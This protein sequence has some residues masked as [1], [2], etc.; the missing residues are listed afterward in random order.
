MPA[1][2][3]AKSSSNT[4]LLAACTFLLGCLVALVAM[5]QFANPA[6]AQDASPTLPDSSIKVSA[7]AVAS[8]SGGEF[9]VVFKESV[10]VL[11]KLRGQP[12]TAMC[13]YRIEGSSDKA[14][15]HLVQSRLI[16]YDFRLQTFDTGRSSFGVDDA[17][18][19]ADE[20]DEAQEKH[21]KEEAERARKE[22]E[23]EARRNR[24][25]SE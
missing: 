25:K 14:D 3:K 18:E 7:L 2:E 1:N 12:V 13:V 5:S 11:G 20:L 22:A 23:K 24:D 4:P 8:Q 15:V 10:G 19:A 21:E 6:S 9:L 17:A 16:D